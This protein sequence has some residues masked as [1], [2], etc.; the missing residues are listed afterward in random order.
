MDRSS[1]NKCMVPYMKGGG[2]DRKL[3]FCIGAKICSGKAKAEDEAKHICL[4]T[5]KKEKTIKRKGKKSDCPK[6]M[7]ELAG[8]VTSQITVNDLATNFRQVLSEALQNCGCGTQKKQKKQTK[9][10]KALEQMTPEHFEALQVI[11]E[12]QKNYEGMSK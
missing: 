8:C 2:E 7:A 5:P 3:R 12:M 6:D 1:Y 4:T 11:G 10:D 9:M